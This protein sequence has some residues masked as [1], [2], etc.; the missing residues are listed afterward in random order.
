MT[1]Y[2]RVETVRSECPVAKRLVDTYRLDETVEVFSQDEEGEEAW[3]T[4]R[5]VGLQH[6]GVWVLTGDRRAW[7]VTNGKRIR[8]QFPSPSSSQERGEGQGEG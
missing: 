3:R 2:D 5:V 8:P 1:R 4:A 6:P 7:Y